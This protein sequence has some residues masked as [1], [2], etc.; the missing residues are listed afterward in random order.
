[1]EHFG[2]VLLYVDRAL[3]AL[4]KAEQGRRREEEKRARQRAED[5]SRRAAFARLPIEEQIAS[6]LEFQIAGFQLKRKRQPTPDEI[7]AMRREL[8]RQRSAEA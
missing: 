4:E 3:D 1:M 7:E 6:R 5:E 8:I 2:G